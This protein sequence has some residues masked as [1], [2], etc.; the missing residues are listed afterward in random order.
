MSRS[1]L[2]VVLSFTLVAA[3]AA[4]ALATE[5]KVV[6]DELGYKLQVDGKDFLILQA[7]FGGPGTPTTGD[8]TGDGQVNDLDTAE[9]KAK[10]GGPPA[11]AAGG[12][13]PEPA[14]GVMAAMAL[15]LAGS[16]ARRR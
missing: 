16:A 10:F 5:A 7:N 4:P 12:A 13:V 3:F 9:F 8:A 2:R 11:V 1:L 6:H 14:V 15:L